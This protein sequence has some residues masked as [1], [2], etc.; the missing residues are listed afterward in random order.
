MLPVLPVKMD[1]ISLK[2]YA[3][4]AQPKIFSVAYVIKKEI[5]ASPAC[6][7]MSSRTTFVTSLI[8]QFPQSLTLLPPQPPIQLK[9]I[10]QPPPNLNQQL[11]Y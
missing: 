2:V 7:N 3:S 4:I 8:P 10:P 1:T 11:R 9:K 6:L 5:L